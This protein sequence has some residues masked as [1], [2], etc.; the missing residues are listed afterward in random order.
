V[1]S[2]QAS[3]GFR[4][5]VRKSLAVETR[6]KLTRGREG[7]KK[8]FMCSDRRHSVPVRKKESFWNGLILGEEEDEDNTT[9]ERIKKNS[10]S[11]KIKK[12]CTFGQLGGMSEKRKKEKESSVEK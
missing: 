12:R 10:E 8:E 3:L 7:K 6:G 4:G 2:A 5:K 11:P 1:H 9:R